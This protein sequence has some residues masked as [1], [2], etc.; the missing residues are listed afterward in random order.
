M[1]LAN[2]LMLVA[3]TT[4]ALGLFAMCTRRT[5]FG[6]LLA[7]QLSVLAAGM[8]LMLSGL[9]SGSH[10]E[11]HLSATFVVLAGLGQLSAGLGLS[12]KM[13]LGRATL[14]LDELRTLKR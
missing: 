2:G 14:S 6:V 12:A 3:A 4:G 1:S 11:G 5:L 7:V 10:S 13:Y 9:R 8:M